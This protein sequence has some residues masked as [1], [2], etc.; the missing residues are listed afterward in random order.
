MAPLL[1]PQLRLAWSACLGTAVLGLLL[2]WWASDNGAAARAVDEAREAYRQ[3]QGSVPLAVAMARQREAND[4]LERMIGLRTRQIGLRPV[5]PFVL[6]ERIDDPGEWFVVT[7]FQISDSLL[8][9]AARRGVVGYEQSLGFGFLQGRPPPRDEV[10]HWAQMLQLVTKTMW[11]ALRVPDN[12]LSHVAIDLGSRVRVDPVAPEGRPHL[13][14]EYPFRL[15]FRANLA[16]VLWLVH[17]LVADM[18]T[19]QHDAL[20][21]WLRE[22]DRRLREVMPRQGAAEATAGNVVSPL[23]IRGL[24]IS[25]AN[26]DPRDEFQILHC[27]LDLAGM[28]FLAREARERAGVVPSASR[29]GGA[30]P[31]A[32]GGRREA[33]P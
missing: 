1:G 21:L 12:S 29:P 19:E 3:R 16:D 28:A 11:L 24:E 6:P 14:D 23:I 2:W 32:A 7:Y 10:A 30:V 27:T 18:P 9:E 15:S 17:Q 5:P 33:M 26:T 8:R 22:V 4:Q 13:L 31:S 25:S 20:Q